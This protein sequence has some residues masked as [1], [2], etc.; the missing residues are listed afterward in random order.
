MRP[1]AGASV[2]AMGPSGKRISRTKRR[3]TR[4]E[5]VYGN[6]PDPAARAAARANAMFGHVQPRFTSDASATSAARARVVD[7]VGAGSSAMP[8]M[9]V[10]SVGMLNRVLGCKNGGASE[11][12]QKG[13]ANELCWL[14][15][16]MSS[17]RISRMTPRPQRWQQRR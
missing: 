13:R 12:A 10:C 2:R 16:P 17:P 9:S 8:Y 6:R 1:V 4:I 5:V 14:A 7:K 3:N 11:M 15:E